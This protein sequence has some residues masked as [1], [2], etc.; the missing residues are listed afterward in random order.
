MSNITDE[1]IEILIEVS[2]TLRAIYITIF[3][4]GIKFENIKEIRDDLRKIFEKCGSDDVS[5]ELACAELEAE[6][7]F[8]TNF[9]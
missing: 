1:Y 7:E 6:V 4:S 9:Q 2:K 5:W 8:G 3:N